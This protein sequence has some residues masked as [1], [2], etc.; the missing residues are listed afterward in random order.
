MVIR[1]NIDTQEYKSK[2]TTFPAA[3]RTRL[4]RSASI[5]EVTPA[6]LVEAVKHGRTFTPAVMTG[7]TADTW[8]AQQV[9]CADIDNDTGRKDTSGKH[10]MLESPLLP[11]EAR[12]VMAQHGINPYF[13]YYSF[14]N[15]D[16]WPKY[17]IVLILDEALTDAAEAAELAARFTGIFNAA[18]EKSADVTSK[19]NARMYYGGRADSVFYNSGAITN[20][21]TLRALPAIEAPTEAIQP[22]QQPARGKEQSTAHMPLQ[23]RLKADIETFNL[24]QY[25][26]QTE[27]SRMKSSG[28]AL[29]FNPCPIC[30]HNDCF[31]VTGNVYHCHSNA[32]ET[33]GTII[34]YLMNREKLDKGAALEKFKFEIM[35]YNKE[36][37]K[38]EYIKNKQ[39]K[40]ETHKARKAQD[41]Q[42]VQQP[43]AAQP[44][45]QPAIND[46][47]GA[48]IAGAMQKEITDFIKAS[49]IKTGFKRFDLLAGG[50]YPGLYVIGAISSLGKTTFIHQVA[51]QIA[52]SGKHVLFFSL[53]MSR[54]EMATKSI[55][56]KTAQLDYSNAVSSLKIRRGVT[57][58]L[59]E[60]AAKAYVTAVADRMNIIEGGFET[61]VNQ[62]SEYTRQYI[63]RHN[64]RPV[65]IVDY[66]QILQG[67]QKNT[68]REAIDFN[69]VELKR[70]SRALDVPV[71]VISSVNRGN[72]LMPVDFESFKESGGIEYTCDVC[73]G[74]QLACLDEPLFDKEKQIKEKRER[75]KQAKGETPRKIKLVC[76]KNRYGSPDWTIDYNYYPQYDYFEEQDGYSVVNEKTP[77]D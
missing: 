31:Q 1:L 48:Y 28:R 40:Q 73:L 7:T 74:L 25:I 71:I 41:A 6:Q 14:S 30:Q 43:A 8:T 59:V 54:L 3:L 75:I 56:R 58:A 60:K 39:E 10:I 34:D 12:A 35:G 5:R 68:I 23:A 2:P 13:M 42:E 19:D 67:A 36:E 26:A 29:F 77:W 50:V 45:E 24:V 17:R 63:A 16:T 66:L 55:S 38:Q 47:I 20:L 64:V 18:R 22:A 70:L 27:K 53:E 21:K 9:I 76:L 32:D 51:D 15:S 65:I 4:C 37:W 72:Y 11:D 46:G 62:I 52:E 61:T 57:S 69:V 49:D 44:A 33:G